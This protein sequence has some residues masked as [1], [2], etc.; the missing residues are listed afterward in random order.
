MSIHKIIWLI[1]LFATSCSSIKKNVATEDDINEVTKDCGKFS[2]KYSYD[3]TLSPDSVYV[4]GRLRKCQT[5]EII[6]YGSVNFKDRNGKT[7]YAKVNS[8]GYYKITL[9]RNF[10]DISAASI[11][12]KLEIPDF[13]MGQYG[14]VLILNVNTRAIAVLINSLVDPKN[15]KETRKWE[16]QIEKLKERMNEE[17]KQE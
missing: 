11:D 10:Y 1:A 15:K 14:N 4:S 5:N 9:A 17:K 7:F 12:S 8:K 6:K 3:T 16:K 2:T 13:E